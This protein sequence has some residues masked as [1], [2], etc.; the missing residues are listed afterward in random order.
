MTTDKKAWNSHLRPISKKRQAEGQPYGLKRT[1]FKKQGKQAKLDKKNLAQCKK[2]ADGMCE[3]CNQAGL[4]HH[5]LLKRSLYPEYKNE[6]CNHIFLCRRCH[7]IAHDQP[8]DTMPGVR[9]MIKAKLQ[10][11]LEQAKKELGI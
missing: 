10:E 3:I 4:D 6:K 5:H 9:Y 11:R 2:N 7:M 1:A 8:T